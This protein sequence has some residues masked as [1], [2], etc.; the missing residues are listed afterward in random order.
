MR[1]RAEAAGDPAVTGLRA[2]WVTPGGGLEEGETARAGA[3]RELREETGIVRAE[4]VLGAPVAER[5][6]DLWIGGVLTRCVEWFYL[7]RAGSERLDLGGW[8]GQER[9][10]ITDV[11][12][13]A[14][15]ELRTADRWDDLI[16]PSGAGGFFAACAE[17]ATP[18]GVT[19][20]SRGFDGGAR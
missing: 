17:G 9:D 14:P 12:W 10:D 13:F 6:G 1:Y 7:A 2:F 11:R 15:D 18:R 20:L 16:A 5:E 8:T 3:C 4:A 19:D